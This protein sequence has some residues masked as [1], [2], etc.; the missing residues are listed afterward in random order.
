MEHVLFY[1]QHKHYMKWHIYLNQIRFRSKRMPPL[2]QKPRK[3][4]F[5]L[6]SEPIA[7]VI[8]HRRGKLSRLD[9]NRLLNNIFNL[10]ILIKY[11]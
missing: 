11:S 5:V 3:V 10:N 8:R 9:K 2:K 1:N 7:M 6:L 4:V